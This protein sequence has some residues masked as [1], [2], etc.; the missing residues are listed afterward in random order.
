MSNQQPDLL[1]AAETAFNLALI[2]LRSA[3]KQAIE[4][5]ENCLEMLLLDAIRKA[6]DVAQLVSMIR[7]AGTADRERPVSDE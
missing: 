5:G 4:H 2:D 6:S 7:R 1:D 3:H